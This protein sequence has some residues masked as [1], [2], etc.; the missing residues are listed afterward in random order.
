MI[1]NGLFAAITIIGIII[2]WLPI[3]LGIV[4]FKAASAAQGAQFTGDKFQ[5]IAS[6]RNI[7]LYFLINGVLMLIALGFMAFAFFFGGMAA[8]MGSDGY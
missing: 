5:L 6:L 3:W 1:L 4:L 8:L 7:K 2:A